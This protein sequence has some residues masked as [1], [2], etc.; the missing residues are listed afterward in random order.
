[1]QVVKRNGNFESVSF[2]KITT[3][4][5]SLCEGLI[6][7]PISISKET[8]NGI[9]NGI[10]TQE[11]DT[12]S[13]DIC[14]SKTHHHPDYNVLAS[15]IAVSN[16]HKQTESDFLKVTESLFDAGIVPSNYFNFVANNHQFIQD[17]LSYERDFLFD[18]FGF[19]TL[20]R[21]Y[22]IKVNGQIVERPQHLWMRVAIQIHGVHPQVELDKLKETYELLSKLY[23]THATPTLFNSGT[24]RPQLASCFLAG[25][26]DT[27]EGIFKSVSDLASISKWAGGIGIHLTNVRCKGSKINGT[28]GKSDGIIPL[29]KVLESVGRYIN[30]GSKRNGS[31]AVYLEPWHGD[32]FEFI[33]LRK[34]TGDENLRTRDLFL[35]M[36]I[37]DLFMKRV[38][39]NEM[40]SLMCPNLCPDLNNTYGEEFEKLY[41]SYEQQG[42]YMKQVPAIDLWHHILESQIE[43]GM[44]YITYKDNVN[45]KSNQKNI[46]IIRSSNLCVAPETRILTDKGYFPIKQLEN[47]NVNVWNGDKWSEVTPV[48]TGENQKLIEVVFSNGLKIVCTPYHKFLVGDKIESASRVSAKDLIP[49]SHRLVCNWNSPVVIKGYKLDNAYSS[50]YNNIK[51]IANNRGEFLYKDDPDSVPVNADLLS[52]VSWISGL[53]DSRSHVRKTFI[54]IKSK[55]PDFII[56]IK[57]MLQTLGLNQT[58][59]MSGSLLIYS[60]DIYELFRLGLR[61]YETDIRLH[62]VKLEPELYVTEV[63]DYGRTDDTYC[64]NEKINHAGVFEGVLTGQCNEIVEYSDSKEYATCNLASLCLPKFVNNGVVEYEELQKVVSVAVTNLNK[65]IDITYYPVP[66]TKYSNMRHRPIGLGVQGLADVYS[67]LDIAFDSDEARIV[68][69]KIFETIYY[70]AVKTSND[71]AKKY[72]AYD[73]FNGSPFSEGKLQFDLWGLTSENLLMNFDWESLKEDVKKYGTRNSLLTALMPTASTAQIMKNNEA[74]EPYS[75]NIYVRKTLAGEYIVVNEYLVKKLLDLGLWNKEMYEEILY[76][77][78]SIQTI[79]RIPEHVRNMYKTAFEMKQVAIVRQAVERGPFIDQTQSM[80]LFQSVPDFDKLSASHFYSWANGLKTGMYYLRT[81][82]AVDPI[83]FG[84]DPSRIQAIKN[85]ENEEEPVI[86]CRRRPADLEGGECVVCSS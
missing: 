41:T 71:L 22:L 12:L 23:F 33:E 68:N 75:S 24:K 59:I 47:T 78:G 44:P 34:N 30:Q 25:T 82:P 85:N 54:E 76:Y 66:E 50:G 86:V 52:K 19:K 51:K 29:C 55:N 77:N 14:A 84:L 42:K 48:K 28:N 27:I 18:F 45:N 53:I 70:S 2:D 3:R 35:A 26:E 21:S 17:T 60:C 74:F 83:K 39:N 46:G 49:N 57:L 15:R 37:P 72:G 5:S 43:T 65:V 32:V 62:N 64:F 1:M 81:Q 61:T 38:K 56:N 79:K 9:Y 73:T 11:L 16:L 13:A 10:K 63:N 58:R 6:V 40:W 31:I 7:D 20:D 4:I 80:N 67:K 8:I 36:W 69:R